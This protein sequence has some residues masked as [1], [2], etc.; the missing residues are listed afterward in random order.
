MTTVDIRK[1]LTEE[2][3]I[4]ES[5]KAIGRRDD[6]PIGNLFPSEKPILK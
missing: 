2:Q 4:L 6:S 3:L 5:L 1:H